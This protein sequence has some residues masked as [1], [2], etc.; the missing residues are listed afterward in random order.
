M[1]TKKLTFS[2]SL[3]AFILLISCSNNAKNQDTTAVVPKDTV[4][5]FKDNPVNQ[6]ARYIAG[7]PQ[8]SAND[9]A[10]FE[11]KSVWMNYSHRVDSI[12]GAYDKNRLSI[13][14]TWYNEQFGKTIAEEKNIYYP[15]SGPD[16]LNIYTLYPNG[17]KY[18]LSGLELVGKKPQPQSLNDKQLGVGLDGLMRGLKTLIERGYFITSYMGKDLY[19]SQL[20]G[21][22]PVIYFFMARTNCNIIE[23][24]FVGLDTAGREHIIT[25]GMQDTS[26]AKYTRGVKITFQ[27][28]GNKKVATMY[29]FACDLEDKG[30]KAHG[31]YVKFV[32][33]NIKDAKTIIKAA[34]YLMHT[35]TFSTMRNLVLDKSKT[36]LNDDSGLPL[37][38]VNDGKWNLTYY[39]AYSGPT[40]DFPY[41]KEADRMKIYKAD[42]TLKKIPF[43]TGYKWKLNQ[44]NL[45]FCVK[46]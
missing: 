33:N 38:A 2:L 11:K 32:K 4:Y 46:K 34:S 1:I 12:W 25:S 40:S 20:N 16:W 45:L 30:I 42:S 3:F 36:I 8:L 41:I 21:V 9:Y 27:H 31:G 5:V 19:A 43:G 22:L 18:V 44:S 17:N 35:P 24:Q 39:G 29:Y 10:A 26:N 13:M 6:A 23:Q 7:M 28:P 37:K 14:R 15:F